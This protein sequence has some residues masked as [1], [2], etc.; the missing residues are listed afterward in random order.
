MVKNMSAK[1]KITNRPLLFGIVVL[2]AILLVTNLIMV[3]LSYFTDVS[4]VNQIVTFGSVETS[5]YILNSDSTKS[6]TIEFDANELISGGQATRKLGVDIIGKNSCYSR[7][8]GD[9]LVNIEGE[10][11]SKVA[12][13][14]VDITIDTVA[15]ANW[16]LA[17]DGLYYCTS[18][19]NT[20]ESTSVDIVFS[21]ARSFG[22]LNANR[23]YKVAI[24]V[25][26]CQAEGTELGTGASFDY[27]K[28]PTNN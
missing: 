27:T 23:D 3:T 26:A 8:S 19:F 4:K 1:S 18:V 11:L 25:E 6:G 17:D 2:C 13:D 12:Y 7:V 22:N 14:H 21:F 5:A 28:W 15:N 16:I 20:G 24:F 9:F 10:W